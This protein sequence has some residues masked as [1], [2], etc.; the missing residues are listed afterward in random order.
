MC[1]YLLDELTSA[2]GTDLN[3]NWATGG[4]LRRLKRQPVV[5]DLPGP[6]GLLDP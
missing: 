1:L 3:R 4:L 5:L 2:V 6:V